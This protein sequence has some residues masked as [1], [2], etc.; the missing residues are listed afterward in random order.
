[1]VRAR[2][3]P[4]WLTPFLKR[5]GPLQAGTSTPH[6]MPNNEKR[7]LKLDR[8]GWLQA[9]HGVTRAPSPN[10]DAR[11]AGDDASLLVLHNISLPPGQ[12]GGTH[13]QDFFLNRLDHGAH[14]WLERIRDMRVSA[15]FFIR[16]D[17]SIVQF[18]S[19]LDRAWHAGASVFEGRERCNDFSIGI[20]LEGTDTEPYADAQYA[21]LQRLLPALRARHPLRAVRG[22]EHIAPGRKTDPGPA[23]DW[24]RFG[25][26]C[27]IQRRY[28]PPGRAMDGDTPRLRP[29][30]A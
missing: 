12:F 20:E 30:P 1:M 18:V 2:A 24:K 8:H 3:C 28:L 26:E 22:H 29:L 4:P 21:A 19:T 10:H 16:R 23:F 6:S 14:P 11:P 25:R 17:G 5:P 13:V 9:A 7:P 15:H 27:G